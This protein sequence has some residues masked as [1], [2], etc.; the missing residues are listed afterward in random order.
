MSRMAEAAAKVVPW[1]EFW[2]DVLPFVQDAVQALYRSTGGDPAKAKAKLREVK[3][4]WGDTD[5]ENDAFRERL[6][7][8]EDEDKPAAQPE[9]K[10]PDNIA[11]GPVYGGDEAVGVDAPDNETDQPG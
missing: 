3:D 4:Q 11:E 5:A 10:V 1:L 9:P 6:A 7:A 8:V 2:G